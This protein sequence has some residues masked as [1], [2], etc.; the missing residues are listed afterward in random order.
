MTSSVTELNFPEPSRE[1]RRAGEFAQ[2]PPLEAMTAQVRLVDESA[3]IA[4]ERIAAE[5]ERLTS[6][7]ARLEA[8]PRA[9]L[10]SDLASA[11]VERANEIRD[12][13]A[14]LSAL[15]E[16]ATKVVA[17]HEA[18]QAAV[19]SEAPPA[20]EQEAAAEPVPQ[21][22]PSPAPVED[23]VSPPLAQPSRVE[24]TPADA[25]EAEAP[26]ADPERR[27]RWLNRRGERRAAEAESRST[28]EGVRLIA[29]QMAIAGS[30]RAE[31]ERRLRVQFGVQDATEALDE[32]FGNRRSEVS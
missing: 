31:I 21:P 22:P 8:G 5:A 27:P 28:S 16:R 13:C 1:E 10:L 11:L 2:Q 9:D 7:D 14:R 24:L 12:D 25:P 32:I 6:S 29:T 15:L 18:T 17:A 20:A 26:A 23:A 4:A 30:S 3:R 19:P